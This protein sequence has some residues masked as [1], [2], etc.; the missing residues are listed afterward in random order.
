MLEI[1][2]SSPFLSIN[3]VIANKSIVCIN[4]LNFKE[5]EELE[6][7]FKNSKISQDFSKPFNLKAFSSK[8]TLNQNFNAISG[9]LKNYNIKQVILKYFNLHNNVYNKTVEQLTPEEKLII[10][11]AF[12]FFNQKKI[13]FIKV[14]DDQ[15]SKNTITKIEKMLISKVENSEGIV[16][17]STYTKQNFNIKNQVMLVI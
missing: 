8:L 3:K 1:K 14:K 5:I 6:T 11:I 4:G 13:W 10:E 16:F 15:I 9:F 17:Y 7:F 12:L 2:Y